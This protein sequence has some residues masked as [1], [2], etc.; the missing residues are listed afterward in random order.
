MDQV[1]ETSVPSSIA[2][3]D[4]G[5]LAFR[6]CLHSGGLLLLLLLLWPYDECRSGN[7]LKSGVDLQRGPEERFPK[8]TL[9]M[10]QFKLGIA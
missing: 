3:R 7:S 9:R 1:Y 4:R 8:L 2:Q 6:A 5:H 10:K